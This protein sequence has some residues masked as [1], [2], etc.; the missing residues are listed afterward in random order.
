MKNQE[1][2][3]DVP[4]IQYFWERKDGAVKCDNKFY[5]K[6]TPEDQ[7]KFPEDVGGMF[8]CRLYETRR[9]VY[10]ECCDEET[11]NLQ[12]EAITKKILTELLSL[13]K[14]ELDILTSALGT[15]NNIEEAF[16]T[17]I[18]RVQ[19]AELIH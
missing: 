8:G 6:I 5:F 7:A 1:Q 4:V 11:W 14:R 18:K 3:I 10:I 17:R 13:P 19:I 2:T 9:Y 12:M 16:D 15:I